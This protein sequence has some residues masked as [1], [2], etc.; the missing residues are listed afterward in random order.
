[1]S[2]YDNPPNKPKKMCLDC[3]NNE[4]DKKKKKDTRNLKIKNFIKNNWRYWITTLL[5]IIVLYM[6]NETLKLSNTP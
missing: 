5:M 1:M 2:T 6:T 3:V 4:K